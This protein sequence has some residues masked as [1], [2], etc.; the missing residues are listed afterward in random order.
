MKNLAMFF[1]MRGNLLKDKIEDE[2]V[3]VFSPIIKDVENILWGEVVS[4]RQGRSE[5]DFWEE[6]GKLVNNK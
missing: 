3:E 5:L 4:L 2:Y 1:E 6:L